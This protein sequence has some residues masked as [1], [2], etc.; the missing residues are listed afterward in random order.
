MPTTP[1]HYGLGEL[2]LADNQKSEAMKHFRIAATSESTLGKKA[3]KQITILEIDR[4]PGKYINT[5][6]TVSQKGTLLVVLQNV[7]PIAVKELEME[8]RLINANGQIA[9]QETIFI[10]NILKPKQTQQTET[11]I[12]IGPAGTQSI[13]VKTT[14]LSLSAAEKI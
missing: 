12:K 14:I 10:A 3:R 1:A 4:N 13:T 8:I 9:G 5:S 6:F 11:Q 2:A 7:A